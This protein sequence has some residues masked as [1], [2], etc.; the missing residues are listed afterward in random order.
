MNAEGLPEGAASE[1]ARPDRFPNPYAGKDYGFGRPTEI[2]S[3]G[4]EEMFAN[5][6]DFVRKDR[7]PPRLERVGI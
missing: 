2:V 6:V 7:G 3:M 1:R 5:P 4:V